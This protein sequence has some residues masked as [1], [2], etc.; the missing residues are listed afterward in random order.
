MATKKLQILDSLIKQAQNADTLDG[1]HADEFASATDVE[2]LKTQV[3]DTSVAE[4]IGS[5]LDSKTLIVTFS[6]GETQ[7]SHT[8][9]QIYEHMQNGGNVLLDLSG[10][11]CSISETRPGLATFNMVMDT[12]EIFFY[13]I[14]EDGSCQFTETDYVFM[15]DLNAKTLI[16][17]ADMDDMTASHTSVQIYEHLQ[18]GGQAFLSIGNKMISIT[19]AR[20]DGY[21]VAS[22]R[23]DEPIHYAYCIYHDGS[24][25]YYEH[26][27]ALEEDVITK[28]QLNSIEFITVNDIDAICG[29]T[30][31]TI[32][33]NSEVTF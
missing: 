10:Q 3:G 31:T 4:Q 15:D 18:N 32:D 5:A 17:T 14:H 29:N 23:E 22:C 2:T 28:N 9:A 30:I 6:E 33:L 12:G 26:S 7:A 13:Y 20:P 24:V 8:S 16:V 11:Y 19:A 21:A 27:Y 1:K 25:E